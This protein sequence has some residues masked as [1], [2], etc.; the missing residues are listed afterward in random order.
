MKQNLIIS[1]AFLVA[2][3]T[4]LYFAQDYGISWD[5]TIHQHWGIETYSIILEFLN[6]NMPYNSNHFDFIS[7]GPGVWFDLL[8]A[9]IGDKMDLQSTQ[10]IYSMRHILTYSIYFLGCIGF[11]LFSRV[12]FEN[13]MHALIATLFYLL[14]PRLLG[15]GFYNFK[16]SIF[17]AMIAI[18]LFPIA[19][20]FL[21][22]NIKWIC[23]SAFLMGMSIA[24]R[25]VAIYIPVIF[26]ILLIIKI[27][28]EKDF[29]RKWFLF[30]FF[31]I[32]SILAGIIIGWPTIIEN[33]IYNIIRNFNIMKNAPWDGGVFFLGKYIQAS[34]LP[35]HYIPVWF[36]ITTPII[37]LFL[38]FVG[39]ITSLRKLLC[40][41]NKNTFIYLFML[42]GLIVPFLSILYFDS[43]LYDGWRH[44]FFIY[45][46]CAFFMYKG[47][48][49]VFVFLKEKLRLGDHTIM[50][51]FVILVFS[52]PIISII[53]LHPHQQIYFNAFAGKDPMEKFEGD[54]WGASYRQGLEWLC[55]NSK[56]SIEVWAPHS[57]AYNN[58]Y[59]LDPELNKK[60]K[61]IQIGTPQECIEELDSMNTTCYYMTNF[62][63][64]QD[65]FYNQS[66]LK[67]SPFNNEVYTIRIGKMKILGI[68]KMN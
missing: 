54:Y 10:E 33:P 44:M 27:L 60:I 68:Y 13:N 25:V 7:Q 55:K 1:L 22:H 49:N 3:F 34:K 19:K 43:T 47:F 9:F 16:D 29:H 18:S 4:G 48:L 15:N 61:F 28:I 57:V 31:F 2:Y 39:I 40:R 67:Q 59:I 35:W 41:K 21:T 5:E 63:Y 46:F 12:V 53:N 56:N 64:Q 11:F 17:Q 38:L 52:G 51:S 30:F 20:A 23:L 24:T 6:S 37:Y 62:R 45:S 26:I 66:K 14:H 8:T 42:C 65:V 36:I 32:L 50:I 58:T